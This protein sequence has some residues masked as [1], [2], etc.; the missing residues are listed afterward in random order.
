MHIKSYTQNLIRAWYLF[1]AQQT[2]KKSKQSVDFVLIEPIWAQA[3]FDLL[4]FI[5]KCLCGFT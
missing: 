4:A 5:F 2:A 3:Q 1:T